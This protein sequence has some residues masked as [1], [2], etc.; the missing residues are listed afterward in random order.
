MC[1][2][3]KR[4]SEILERIEAVI[5]NFE[6]IDSMY[7]IP[8]YRVDHYALLIKYYS[9]CRRDKVK[10]LEIYDKMRTHTGRVGYFKRRVMQSEKLLSEMKY[11]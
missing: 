4:R 2:N 3:T 5:T 8:L 7:R 9:I 10:A 6:E 11:L 1:K